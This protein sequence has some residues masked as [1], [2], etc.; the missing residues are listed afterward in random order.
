MGAARG[1]VAG[2]REHGG[3]AGRAVSAWGGPIPQALLAMR[4]KGGWSLHPRG[5]ECGKADPISARLPGERATG[6]AYEFLLLEQM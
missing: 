4:A 3:L 5:M 1:M 6:S 2:C